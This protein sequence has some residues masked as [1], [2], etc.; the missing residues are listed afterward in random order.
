MSRGDQPEGKGASGAEVPWPG[1]LR[2]ALALYQAGQLPAFKLY[3]RLTGPRPAWWGYCEGAARGTVEQLGEGELGQVFRVIDREEPP[4]SPRAVTDAVQA[5]YAVSRALAADGKGAP[6]ELLNEAADRWRKGPEVPGQQPAAPF[7]IDVALAQVPLRFQDRARAVLS[8]LGGRLH[9][10][11]EAMAAICALLLAGATPDARRAVQVRVVLAVREQERVSG[12]TGRLDVQVLPG[13]PAGLYPDPRAL[14]VQPVNAAFNRALHLAWQSAGGD[15]Q[16]ACVLWRVTPDADVPGYGIDGSSLGAAFAISLQQLLRRRPASRLFSLATLGGSLTRL[17]PSC[18][19][20]GELS[21]ERPDA[22]ASL[23]S[24]RGPWLA[25]VGQLDAKLKAVAARQLR[26]VAPAANKPASPAEIP[27]DVTVYWASTLRQADRYARRIRPVRTAVTALALAVLI[28]GSAGTAVALHY[29]SA[30]NARAAAQHAAALSAELVSL[31]TANLTT[32]LNIAQLL[33]VEATRIDN[34]PQAEA[35]LFQAA[36]ASPHLERFIDVGAPVTA[37]AAAADGNIVVAG[38]S[39]GELIRFNLADGT[40]TQASAGHQPI[41]GISVSADGSTVAA[42]NGAREFA[43]TAASGRPP[44]AVAVSGSAYWVAVSPSGRLV[45]L[46]ATQ[47]NSTTLAVENT[48]SGAT[49]SVAVQAGGRLAFTSETGLIIDE[50]DGGFTQYAVPGLRLIAQR[51]C[52]GS[53]ANGATYGTSPNG[54]YSGYTKYGEIVAWNNAA[55]Y[56]GGQ[57]VVRDGTGPDVE[58]LSL[59]FSDDGTYAAGIDNGTITVSPLTSAAA[60]T[61]LTGTVDTTAVAFLGGDDRLVSAAGTTLALW[62]LRQEVSP[63]GPTDIQVPAMQTQSGPAELAVSPDGRYLAIFDPNMEPGEANAGPGPN[64]Q[65]LPV[66]TEYRLEAASITR[67]GRW[68]G[69]QYADP[70][71]S[72][73]Q[74]VLVGFNGNDGDIVISRP[75]GTAIASFPYHQGPLSPGSQ[76]ATRVTDSEILIPDGTGVITFDPLTRTGAFQPVPLAGLSRSGNESVEAVSPDGTA[77]VLDENSNHPSTVYL[78][79]RTGA[80]HVIETGQNR[81]AVFTA[82]RLLIQDNGAVQEWDASGEHLLQT[83]PAS[84]STTFGLTVSPDGTKIAQVDINGVASVTDL[85]TGRVIETFTLPIS[86]SPA[87]VPAGITTLAFSRDGQYLLTATPGDVLSRWDTSETSLAAI[88]CARAGQSLTPA[89]WASYVNA[90]LPATLACA[91]ARAIPAGAFSSSSAAGGAAATPGTAA[92][93][94]P[95][96][97]GGDL[98]AVAAASASDAWAVGNIANESGL[99]MHWNGQAW[100]QMATPAGIRNLTGVTAPSVGSAW[101]VG[102]TNSDAAVVLHWDGTAWTTSLT[103]GR[104]DSLTV[105]GASSPDD[106]WAAGSNSSSGFGEQWNGSA[107][108]QVPIP[109]RKLSN[110]GAVEVLSA[111]DAW[112]VGASPWGQE[113]AHWNGTSW[114]AAPVPALPGDTGL[115]AVSALS[116]TDAWAAGFD[117]NKGLLEHWNGSAWQRVPIPPTVIEMTGVADTGTGDAWA[118]GMNPGHDGNVPIVLHWNGGSWTQVSSPSQTAQPDELNAMT[119]LSAS[120]A[121]A[122][123]TEGSYPLILKLNG[124]RWNIAPAG[125]VEPAVSASASAIPT[126]TPSAPSAPPASG[127]GVITVDVVGGPVAPKILAVARQVLAAA[128]AHDSAALDKLLGGNGSQTAVAL[129]KVL[130]QPGVYAQIVTL[131]TRTHTAGQDGFT[132]WPGFLLAGGS[133]PLAVADLQVLGV[134][135][136]QA[137]KGITISIGASYTER[138]NVPML[139]SIAQIT[140]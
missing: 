58:P 101:A 65:P 52:C 108:R 67:V 87:N 38:T 130:A 18:A 127:A 47:G 11:G 137:Y 54:A 109:S 138:P 85:A 19:I 99:I 33:A 21:G 14:T 46:L 90:P 60:P 55:S 32:H 68:E 111:T 62:N 3:K 30:A 112:A 6:H 41:T 26:L 131:L 102:Y 140:S 36:T 82:G 63:E 70:V 96:I 20:T 107:W 56:V 78:N 115:S 124:T 133:A 59:T 77:A 116:A 122:V 74:L 123:G 10:H 31:S 100:Q 88:A 1:D 51:G 126:P 134:A 120:D 45:A 2:E 61:R 132:I 28:G 136:P 104:N 113:I 86:Q 66:L 95:A 91:G 89:I 117:R 64:P 92:S 4:Q 98:S 71:W 49:A 57:Q 103:L 7:S 93:A 105:I 135:S 94:Q 13:G 25:S 114:V 119:A 80:V 72:G 43:W 29:D 73:D 15:S 121:W 128:R 53:P 129:N 81:A 17:R 39:G 75:D 139:V 12:V 40:H 125:G 97:P 44:V 24:H 22:Y 50:Y 69:Q 8:L 35:A 106:V 23:A 9:D 37:L 83:L 27:A 110:F 79:L 34:T 84:G 118:V 42:T 16:Q 48:G 5:V 76:F